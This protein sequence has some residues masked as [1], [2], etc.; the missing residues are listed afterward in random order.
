MSQCRQMMSGHRR[1]VVAITFAALLVVPIC[2]L[3]TVATAVSASPS[4][5]STVLLSIGEMPIGWVVDSSSGSGGIGCL[6]TLM[7]PKGVQQTAKAGALF[8]NNGNVPGVDEAVATYTNAAT[9]YNK[10]VASL[11]ACKRLSGKLGGQK[12]TG[13]LA[14]MSF[15]GYGNASE[16]FEARFTVYGATLGGDIVIVRKASIVMALAE[17]DFVSVNVSQFQ[18]FVNEAVAKLPPTTT[19]APSGNGSSP[20]RPVPFGKTASVDGWTVKLVSVTPESTDPRAGK[21]PKG[22]LFEIDTLQVTRT[23]ATPSS[24]IGLDPELVGL[25]HA[26]R[27]AGTS[28]RCWGVN[29]YNYQVD[30]GRTVKTS[31]CISVPVADASGLAVGVGGLVGN[32]TWFAAK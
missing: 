10:I 25:T 29:S 24:P 22:Y 4:K 28:P 32:P 21:P 20:S 1:R 31:D 19:T 3:G 6:S 30:K 9:G 12:I 23:A 17:A 26:V 11:T 2:L 14:Q 15:P 7:E 8:E 27:K 16:A 13:T 18:G 5:L